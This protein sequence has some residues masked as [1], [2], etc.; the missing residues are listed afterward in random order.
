ML[1]EKKGNGHIMPLARHSIALC[2]KLVD[3]GCRIELDGNRAKVIYK[4]K[5]ILKGDRENN[6]WYLI[7]PNKS[8]FT[9]PGMLDPKR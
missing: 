6:M 4:D 9:S 1:P 5:V 2:S 8:A 7:L 3:A